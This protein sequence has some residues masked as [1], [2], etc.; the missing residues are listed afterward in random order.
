[1]VHLVQTYYKS[2]NFCVI[3]P[4]DAQRAAIETGL[5]NADLPWDSVYNLD[6]F[7]GSS[8]VSTSMKKKLPYAQRVAGKS[9]GI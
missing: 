7:Q 1:M 2:T 6:S 4:Y 3:T 9:D 5:K 8:V